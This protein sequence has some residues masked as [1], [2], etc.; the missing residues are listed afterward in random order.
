MWVYGVCG[1][2]LHGCVYEMCM[3]VIVVWGGC[4]RWGGSDVC[5]WLGE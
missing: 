3:E 2:F 1:C 4:V 5:R